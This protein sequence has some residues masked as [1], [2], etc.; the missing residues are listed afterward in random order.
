V[1]PRVGAAVSGHREAYEYL[2]ESAAVFPSG[3]AFL[4]RMRGVCFT[5]AEQ[6]RLTFGVASLYK[7]YREA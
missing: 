5:R 1:L 7:G 3:E 2:Q 4:S 6:R